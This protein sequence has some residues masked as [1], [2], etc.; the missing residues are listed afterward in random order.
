MQIPTA[1]I[2]IDM[3]FFQIIMSVA[4]GLSAGCI[5]IIGYNVGAGRNDRT[6]EILKRLLIYKS[7]FVRSLALVRKQGD[8]HIFAG[9]RQCA[10]FNAF[11][12]TA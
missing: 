2:D 5:P 11:V 1:V 10:R 7:V 3:K 8:I 4:I 6:L 9:S 12:A